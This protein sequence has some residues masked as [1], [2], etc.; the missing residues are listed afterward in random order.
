MADEAKVSKRAAAPVKTLDE[1]LHEVL[2]LQNAGQQQ[3]ADALLKTLHKRFPGEN[4][5]VRMKELKKN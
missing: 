1:Q 5:T 3:A 2:R 4:L